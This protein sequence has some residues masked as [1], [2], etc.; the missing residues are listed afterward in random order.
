MRIMDYSTQVQN[1]GRVRMRRVT[2]APATLRDPSPA[3]DRAPSEHRQ[4]SSSFMCKRI[5]VLSIRFKFTLPFILKLDY[6]V[7][8]FNIIVDFVQGSTPSVVVWCI[9]RQP[10]DG[11]RM[12]G[13]DDENCKTQWY[14]TRCLRIKKIP[15]GPWYCPDCISRSKNNLTK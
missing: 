13:C 4:R 6:S 8:S 1:P 11:T 10:D 7:V 9:C 3:T 2:I 14:H 15:K 5:V 12:I